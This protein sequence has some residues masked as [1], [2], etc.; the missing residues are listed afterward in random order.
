MPAPD[1]PL[2]HCAPRGL[3][4]LIFDMDGVLCDTMPFHLEAWLRY[5][6]SVPE[7]AAVRRD[8]LEQMGGQRNEELLPELLGYP[9]SGA[10]LRRW[11]AEKEAVYRGLIE[12]QIQWLPGLVSFLTQAQ[13]FGFKLGLGTSACRENVELLL[14]HE[15]LGAFFDAQVID[16]DVERGKP[17]PDCYQL[18]AERL[19]VAPEHCLVF[20]DATAGVQAARRAGMACWGVL[21][22][23]SAQALYDAGAQSCIT[24]FQDLKLNVLLECLSNSSC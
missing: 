1:D 10:D 14:S 17:E 4:A 5:S 12:N 16:V 13:Q 23:C 8:R 7:L 21:T 6:A 11:G 19:G 18:V 9:V 15:N 3:E 20:E 22:T 2:S 24:D